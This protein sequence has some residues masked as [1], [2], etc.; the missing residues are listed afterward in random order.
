MT[1]RRPRLL[2]LAAAVM[3]SGCGARGA[4]VTVRRDTWGVPHVFAATLPDAAYGLGYAQAEDR[5]EQIFANYRLAIG[6]MAEVEGPSAVED[7]WVQRLAGTADVCRRRYP[8]LPPEVR[9]Y[10]E[11]YQ[12]GVKAYLDKFPAKRPA[13]YLAPEPWMVPAVGRLMILNWPLGHAKQLLSK[14]GQVHFY[15][16]EWAVR[17]DRTADGAAILLIDPHV[18]WDGPFRCY[19]FRLHAGGVDLSG[20]GPAGTP[21]VALGHN[22][23]LGWA[24]T[25]G[26]PLTTDVYVE[27]LDP[28]NPQR[29]RYDDGWREI[30]SEPVTIK[31][32][33]APDVRRALERSHHGPIAQ[34]ENGLAYAVASPYLDQIDCISQLYRMATARNL[35][36][37]NQAL[38]MRQMMEQ[39]IMYADV[40]GHIQYVRNGRVPIRPEGFDYRLPVPGNT[41]QSEWLGLHDFKD[42]LR[43]TDPATGYLQNC[44]IGPDMMAKN[45]GL[46]PKAW[47]YYLYNSAAGATNSRG[48]R[49]VELLE[50]NPKLT[51]EQ[52]QA[53][54]LDT[55]ADGCER[56]LAALQ[57]AAAAAEPGQPRGGVNAADLQAALDALAAWNGF[58]TTDSAAATLY[59]AW[60]MQTAG[61]KLTETSPPGDLL[62]AFAESVALIVTAAGT[63]LVPYGTVHRVRRGER[64]FAVAG[65]DPGGG[66]CLR[67]VD[68]RFDGKAFYG[69]GG[70]NWTQLVQFRPGAVRSWSATPY[71]ESDDPASPHYFDQGEKLFGPG[72]L[73]PTWFGAGE[74]EG[75]VESTEV[76]RP[77]A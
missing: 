38:A 35:S 48:R 58:M 63:P 28:A 49:A 46:D 19:E 3:L 67:A 23:Y 2:S 27:Q 50:A 4:E 73:K 36:E 8:E 68:A 26:G 22:A 76:L 37:F 34:R 13:T 11:S 42:L 10:C 72:R 15:S 29:Y 52:A 12:A 44:N 57:K 24:C 45:L 18:P 39:N 54:V 51:I 14:R 59:R 64:S 25:T 21:L 70:Q 6:A 32:K 53:I 9:A 75:H 40:E 17:P 56:W 1:V 20:F 62:D 5:I 71:G 33:G 55:H 66:Q 77:G 7:D 60:R 43:V 65:G 69:Y 31:V 30:S 16:N 61:Q 74:L 41:S 47:P